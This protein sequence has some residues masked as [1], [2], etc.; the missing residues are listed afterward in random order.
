MRMSPRGR[1]A[2]VA[3]LAATALLPVRPATAFSECT[4]GNSAPVLADFFTF[5]Y[6]EAV[7]TQGYCLQTGA[8]VEESNLPYACLVFGIANGGIQAPAVLVGAGTRAP[9]ENFCS[10]TSNPAMALE[11]CQEWYV[12]GEFSA[13]YGGLDSM[14]SFEFACA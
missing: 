14:S 8:P 9:M 10:A 1:V 3:T 12:R 13:F 7:R 2:A 6:V 11:D 5:F 4:I